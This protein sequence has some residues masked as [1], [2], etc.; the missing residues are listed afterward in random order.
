MQYFNWFTFYLRWYDDP[1]NN[2]YGTLIEK[3]MAYLQ[4]K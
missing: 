1:F 3:T 4:L 2:H